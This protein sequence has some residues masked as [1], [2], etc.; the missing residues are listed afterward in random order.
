MPDPNIPMV[1]PVP[2]ITQAGFADPVWPRWLN[3]LRSY[4]STAVTNM[5]VEVANG[6]AGTVLRDPG[7]NSAVL[8]I[9]TSVTGLAK[10][11]AG[12]LVQ[13]VPGVDYMLPMAYG[14]FYDTTQQTAAAATPTP[15]TFNTTDSSSGIS[16][17]TPTSRVVATKAGIYNIQFSLQSS[18]PS[19][20]ADNVTVWIRKNGVDVA[21]SGGIDTCHAKHGSIN[22]ASLFGWNLFLRL[23]VGDYI[24]MVWTTDSGTSSLTT[25]PASTPPPVH[26]ASPCVILTLTQIGI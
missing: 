25:Y 16:L 6:F 13:A 21:N 10:G 11:A 19:A 1:P 12:G 18:N 8:T 26:P 20:T 23:A 5:R 7:M 17:G 3:Q 2:P 4:V 15:I 14:S 9:S 22:G 24:E